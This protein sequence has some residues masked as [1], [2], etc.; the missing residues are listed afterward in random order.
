MSRISLDCEDYA[1]LRAIATR[2]MEASY[3]QRWYA[4]RLLM[5]RRRRL[6]GHVYLASR[7]EDACDAIYRIMRRSERW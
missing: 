3:H 2:R 4:R 1:T 7:H 6:R 5:A